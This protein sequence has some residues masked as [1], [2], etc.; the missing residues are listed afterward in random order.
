MTQQRGA[1]V[2]GASSGI[3]EALSR[4]LAADG[5]EIGLAAR[6]TERMRRIGNELPTKS[7]VATMDVTAVEDAR[8]G[9]FDLA[10]A[11]PSVDL[12]VLSAGV[13]TVNRDLE[14]EPERQ[15]IDVNVRGFTALATAAM[16]YFESTPDHASESDGHLVG[17][18]SV[19]AHIGNDDAPAYSASKAYVSTYLEGLRY[20]EGDRDTD[21]AIT[22]IEPGFVDTKLSLGGFWECSPETAAAQIARAIE[23]KRTHAYVT[24]R[25][26]A[27]AWL[28]DLLPERLRRRL[29]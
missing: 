6:R 21:V 29:F 7:Y 10:E 27:I 2:V 16:E 15:T 17:I 14:W 28:V 22:T 19:A 1:I 11:M 8:Q 18:S 12:V 9:F 4:R 5:Y 20:R 13:A 23:K 24:R 3:G 26:R 25:W